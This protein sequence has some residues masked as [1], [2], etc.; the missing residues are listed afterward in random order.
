MRLLKDYYERAM[1]RIIKS[2]PNFLDVPKISESKGCSIKGIYYSYDEIDRECPN[3]DYY[4]LITVYDI[5][6]D[7][8]K[9]LYK[10]YFIIENENPKLMIKRGLN[11]KYLDL[12]NYT[13]LSLSSIINM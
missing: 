9:S 10:I 5:M 11:N 2:N 13:N 7:G 12:D 1:N 4:P 8:V 3:Q 6:T